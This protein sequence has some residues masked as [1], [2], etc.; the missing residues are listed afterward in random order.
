MQ[1]I[2]RSGDLGPT[3][4]HVALRAM[5]LMSYSDELAKS[6]QLAETLGA[7]P[8]FVRKI[9]IQLT[10][11][12]LV[13]SHGGRYGGYALKKDPSEITVG[14]I[15]R[16]LGATPAT[17]HWTVPATG[18]ELFISLMISRAEEEFQSILDKY[19]IEDIVKQSHKK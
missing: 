7:D 16:A 4:F 9:L 13:V 18:S 10:K 6:H 12:D 11:S 15:Y 8:T 3:W 17:P 19:T 5:V 14:E 2:L 1:L